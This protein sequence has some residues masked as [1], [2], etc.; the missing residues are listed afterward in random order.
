M[1]T[2]VD[3]LCPDAL[4]E[5]WLDERTLPD[6]DATTLEGEVWPRQRRGQQ[7]G[8][9]PGARSELDWR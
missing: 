2:R 4:D 9:A 3:G 8:G 1:D 7:S 6:L 5:T